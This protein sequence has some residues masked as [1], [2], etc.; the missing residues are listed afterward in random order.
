M[1]LG[2][3]ANEII[4][5]FDI[6]Q[7]TKDLDTLFND[8]EFRAAYDKLAADFATNEPL[9]LDAPIEHEAA[10][11]MSISP[12]VDEPSETAQED[13][14]ENISDFEKWLLE[15]ENSSPDSNTPQP[16]MT[17]EFAD[18]CQWLDDILK[19]P[20]QTSVDSVYS[21]GS[22]SPTDVSKELA[23]KAQAVQQALTSEQDEEIEI[24]LPPSAITYAHKKQKMISDDLRIETRK[25]ELVLPEEVRDFQ[26]KSKTKALEAMKKL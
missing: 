5:E 19:E 26:R 12:P 8:P 14:S 11:F 10:P 2:T 1:L 3:T 4:E 20:E 18:F 13:L 16:I 15:S 25:R 6:D 24:N 22:M 21:D 23:Q 9:S 7:F 17:G